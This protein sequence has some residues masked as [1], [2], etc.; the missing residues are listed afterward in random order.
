MSLNQDTC[1]HSVCQSRNKSQRC[2][3]DDPCDKTCL[4]EW[5]T[6]LYRNRIVHPWPQ[7]YQTVSDSESGRVQLQFAYK[8]FDGELWS[9]QKPTT[10]LSLFKAMPAIASVTPGF[11]HIQF[12]LAF[13]AAN[14]PTPLPLYLTH[15]GEGKQLTLEHPTGQLNQE[16]LND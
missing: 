9:I 13:S 12:G 11:Y 15:N 16:V 3:H 8:G 6:S 2:K 10:F 4:H 5:K 14:L 7:R 1:I